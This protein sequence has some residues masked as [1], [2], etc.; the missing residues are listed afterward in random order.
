MSNARFL[1]IAIFTAIS[2]NGFAQ[3]ATG[4][5]DQ[6][7]AQAQQ[8]QAQTKPKDTTKHSLLPSV[9]GGVGV[10]YFNGNIGQ[11]S[12]VTDYST[13]R[14]G[15]TFGV[16]LRPVN[17]LG[18][19]LNCVIGKLAS[20]ERS[21]TPSENRNF[22]SNIME[23][24]L[25]INLHFL[26]KKTIS[27]WIYTGISYMMYSTYTDLKDAAGDSYYYWTDG[28]IR[29]MPQTAQSIATG[30]PANNYWIV[31]RSYNYSTFLASG[32]TECV[33]IGIGAKMRLTENLCINVQAAY[34]FTF[35][36]NIEQLNNVIGATS[37][38]GS[39]I[40][41]GFSSKTI[42]DKYLFSLCTVEYQF[43]RKASGSHVDETPYINVDF[44]KIDVN[45]TVTKSEISAADLAA[46]EQK[47][48]HHDTSAVSRS[49]MF[50]AHPTEGTIKQIE[51][52]Q[53]A[54]G[55]YSYDKLPARFRPADKNKDGYI[56][57]EEI[58]QTIDDFFE[59]TSPMTIKDINDLIDYFFEQD[60]Q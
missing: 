52:E 17:F 50:N 10:L 24:E 49:E 21:D 44:T 25:N 57:A 60:D 14:T 1:P 28:S 19:Q 31:Q 33:P 7:Q 12:G 42:N 39:S 9:M 37:S 23:G 8:P 40:A 54:K 43:G 55:H 38:I 47:E 59:G 6:T 27:P 11:G 4:T 51:K 45:D 20:S 32:S 3:S 36:N 26:S 56:S 13:V 30:T 16:E 34:Y 22:Q 46:L 41:S 15:Y 48:A 58:T 18:L 29:S 53:K 2:L 35:T 5:G